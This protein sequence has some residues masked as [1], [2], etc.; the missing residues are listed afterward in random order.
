LERRAL[1]GASPG[2]V[3]EEERNPREPAPTDRSDGREVVRSFKRERLHER[4]ILR[5]Q[6]GGTGSEEK[7]S[8]NARVRGSCSR[9]ARALPSCK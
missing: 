7:A 1:Y 2:D 9:S 5:R 4:M 8:D 6:A 3:V